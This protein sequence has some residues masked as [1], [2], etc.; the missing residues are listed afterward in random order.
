MKIL[1]G[2]LKETL[3]HWPDKVQGESDHADSGVGS[4][5]SDDDEKEKSAAMKV[6]KVTLLETD[7]VAYMHDKLGL[8][9]VSNPLDFEGSV[10]LHLYTPPYDTCKTFNERSSKARSSGK[11]VYFSSRGERIRSCEEYQKCSLTNV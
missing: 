7:S 10:S 6:K 8:H 1:G 2:T 3:Y 11:C 9:A 5:G 4:D